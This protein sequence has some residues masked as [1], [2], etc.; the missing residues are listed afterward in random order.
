M[1]LERS[2]TNASKSRD[3]ATPPPGSYVS[4]IAT[5]LLM[6]WVPGKVAVPA[7]ISSGAR[8]GPALWKE[9]YPNLTSG[10]PGGGRPDQLALVGSS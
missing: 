1:G 10:Y 2:R 8:G 5:D 4:G 7:E 6:T 3:S 9:R